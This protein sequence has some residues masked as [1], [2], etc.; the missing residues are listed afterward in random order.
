MTWRRSPSAPPGGEAVVYPYSCMGV[1]TSAH[2]GE[3][4]GGFDKESEA[5]SYAAG[6]RLTGW[7]RTAG[8]EGQAAAIRAERPAVRLG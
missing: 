6:W 5:R 7:G 4:E 8:A 1:I 2:W 3:S